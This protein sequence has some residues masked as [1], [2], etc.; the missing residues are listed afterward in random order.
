MQDVFYN[1]ILPYYI[2]NA[3]EKWDMSFRFSLLLVSKKS[4]R[5]VEEYTLNLSKSNT[6]KTWTPKQFDI[7]KYV[8]RFWGISPCT[9]M[10]V[11]KTRRIGMTTILQHFANMYNGH[12]KLY[13]SFITKRHIEPINKTISKL[14][15]SSTI[16]MNS[17]VIGD[18]LFGINQILLDEIILKNSI[19]IIVT[20]T[21]D[22]L[23]AFNWNKLYILNVYFHLISFFVFHNSLA[24]IIKTSLGYLENLPTHNKVITEL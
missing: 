9:I 7:I 17:L 23:T 16:E 8:E 3:V 5:I 10:I 24:I 21:E 22:I 15:N 19:Y 6:I 14:K 20:Y 4:K 18:A 12:G 2:H 1:I 13:A 11:Q